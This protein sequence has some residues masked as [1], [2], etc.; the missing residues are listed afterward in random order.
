MQSR[1]FDNLMALGTGKWADAAVIK[2]DLDFI[3]SKPNLPTMREI[4]K[5]HEVEIPEPTQETI[6]AR[7]KELRGNGLSEHKVRRIIKKEFHIVVF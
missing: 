3:K 7:I 6:H 1:E 4:I 5:K 2:R